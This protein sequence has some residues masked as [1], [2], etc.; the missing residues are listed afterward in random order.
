MQ[1]VGARPGEKQHEELVDDDESP[2]PS[3]YPGIVVAQ[4]PPPDP[5]ALRR[6]LRELESLARE[7]RRDELADRMRIGRESGVELPESDVLVTV[8]EAS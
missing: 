1:V 2:V 5:A 4:P 3:G 6:R 7:G 8:G